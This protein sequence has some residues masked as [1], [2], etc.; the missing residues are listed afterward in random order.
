[1]ERA[2]CA[3]A[4]GIVCL[5]L[6]RA[7]PE[8]TAI[9]NAKPDV[10]ILQ[11]NTSAVWEGKRYDDAMIKLFTALSFTGLKVGFA[12]E[13]QLEEGKAPDAPILFVP[14]SVHISDPAFAGLKSFK[15]KLV[16]CGDEKLLAQ[17]EYDQPR[18]ERI[19]ATVMP[20][21]KTWQET[22]KNLLAEL[23]A[24][25]IKVECEGGWGVQWQTARMPSGMV[26]N[27]YNAAHDPKVLTIASDTMWMDVLSG[28]H[29]EA[30]EKIT[31]QPMEVRLLRAIAVSK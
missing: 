6:N 29:V 27:L 9:Q 22:L 4:V 23:P 13:R 15:G 2:G 20:L 12:L 7:A 18:E 8:I 24:P 1:M 16:F 28:R 10:L 14:N 3:E 19:T 30:G 11:D 5:D 21:G 25:A 17:N 31:L 26:V